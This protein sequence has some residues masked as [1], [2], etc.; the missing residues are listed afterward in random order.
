VDVDL[1]VQQL[2]NGPTLG[3]VYVLL[4][5]GYSMVCGISKLLNFALIKQVHE[6]GVSMLMVE[7]NANMALPS[8]DHG[9]GLVTGGVALAGES[10]ALLGNAEL[11]R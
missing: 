3:S 7:Q 2:M 10:F 9:Y 8:V 1:F 5:T 11:G 6:S 4:A